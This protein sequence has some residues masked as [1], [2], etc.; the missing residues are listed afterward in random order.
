MQTL[1]KFVSV[2]TLSMALVTVAAVPPPPPVAL[3]GHWEGAITIMGSELAIRVDFRTGAPGLAATIDIPQQGASTL[4]LKSVS[5]QP[6]RVH[7]ELPAGPGL[8]TFE[9]VAAG[10]TIDGIFSQGA[11][12]GTFRLTRQA[13]GVVAPT[14]TPAPPYREEEV[15]FTT[16]AGTFAGTLTAPHGAGRHPA[17]VLITGSGPQNR[18]EELF[19]FK[20]F[21]LIADHLTRRGV[22][23]LRCDD[24]GVGG[25]TAKREG[26]TTAD[27]AGD[28]L[29]AV[30]FLKGRAEVDAR[31]IGLLG[32]S[33]GGLVAPI[34]AAQ[35]GDVAFIVLVSASGVTG[36]RLMLAQAEAIG[37]AG[38]APEAD[39]KAEAALQKRLFGAARSGAG[40]DEVRAEAKALALAKLTALPAEQRQA[41]GD[42]GAYADRVIA[43]QITMA[44]TPWFRY[45]LDHDP[46][47]DLAQVRCPVLAL[48]G[49]KDLQVP[50]E[51]NREAIAA[52]LARGGNH[53]VTTKVLPGANH[54]YQRAVTGSPDEYP[55]LPKEFVAGFL[56]TISGWIEARQGAG[57]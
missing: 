24:R 37:R 30:A 28:A 33:E 56:D 41:I 49:E 21:R 8:A 14:P 7:F 16:P 17:V 10:E 6:P 57:S 27:Y 5:Y 55:T 32:H 26:S 52:A 3:D 38:G 36:E 46:A 11:A 25:T 23:V 48:F 9:G 20:P 51:A 31:R 2:L 4:P 50:A 13:V 19:G 39:L 12:S 45:F 42:L 40:W 29:A 54:L 47:A 15:S 35:S 53:G 43:G 34:A 44:Q 18:D 22:V 1:R